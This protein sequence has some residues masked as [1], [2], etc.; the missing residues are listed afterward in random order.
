[1]YKKESTR[2]SWQLSPF[3]PSTSED[4]RILHEQLSDQILQ[5]SNNMQRNEPEVGNNN[6][7]SSIDE[8]V[9]L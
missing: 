7:A 5:M 4:V 1:M 3:S 2:E 6:V 8:L 9:D